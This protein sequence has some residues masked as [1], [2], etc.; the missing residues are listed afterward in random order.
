MAELSVAD[1][2][3]LI[4]AT[5]EANKATAEAAQ[6][7]AAR[8][9]DINS[10]LDRLSLSQQEI[11]RNSAK[12]DNTLDRVLQANTALDRSVVD[13]KQSMELVASR[14]DAIEKTRTTLSTPGTTDLYSGSLRPERR[15]HQ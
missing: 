6:A 12:V 3:Q 7:N 9:T 11:V 5:A 4:A 2:R 14:L 13:L 15:L 1:L 8:I 10:V